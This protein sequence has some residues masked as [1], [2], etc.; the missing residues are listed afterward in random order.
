MYVLIFH[1]QG[2]SVGAPKGRKQFKFMN[3]AAKS[4]IILYYN[5][6]VLNDDVKGVACSDEGQGQSHSSRFSWS[7]ATCFIYFATCIQ[8]SKTAEQ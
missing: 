4:D 2:S 3:K 1:L 5:N 7:V 8:M 6:H